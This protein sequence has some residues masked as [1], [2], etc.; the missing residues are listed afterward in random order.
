MAMQ[1]NRQRRGINLAD[2]LIHVDEMLDISEKENIVNDLRGMPGVISSRFN[3]GK[4]H[5]LLVAFDPSE[6][7]SRDLLR[8]VQR[9]GFHAESIGL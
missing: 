3:P 7:T 5:L 2:T 4:D 6:T 1:I 8:N 9:H